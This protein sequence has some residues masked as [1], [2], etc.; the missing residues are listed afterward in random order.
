[1]P[2]RNNT[3][4]TPYYIVALLYLHTQA[5]GSAYTAW[6]SLLACVSY[7]ATKLITV[8]KPT[9]LCAVARYMLL[10]ALIFEMAQTGSASHIPA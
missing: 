3:E 8:G 4:W 5:A 1:M 6:G 9:P 7:T 10:A 2:T